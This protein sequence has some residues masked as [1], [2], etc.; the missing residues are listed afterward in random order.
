MVHLQ[1]I[2]PANILRAARELIGIG[3]V[4]AATAAGISRRSIQ[5]LERGER[6]WINGSI[7]L[8]T[9]YESRGVV[10]IRPANGSG[11]GLID[12]SVRST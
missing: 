10:F 12:N 9:Y 2:A 5:R 3:Q 7:L 8:Q 11:W 1:M 6:D 4:E